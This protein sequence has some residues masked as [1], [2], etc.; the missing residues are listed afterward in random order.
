M[1]GDPTEGALIVVAAKAGLNL[2]NLQQAMPRRTAIL[3][4]FINNG[5]GC[6]IS[7]SHK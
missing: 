1:A 4:N 5:N 3:N 7:Y 6:F 2:Q